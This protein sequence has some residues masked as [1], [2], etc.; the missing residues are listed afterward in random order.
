MVRPG[1]VIPG[2]ETIIA[3]KMSYSH[4]FSFDLNDLI[5][6]MKNIVLAGLKQACRIIIDCV[7]E[8]FYKQPNRAAL[9]VDMSYITMDQERWQ[10][11]LVD[12]WFRRSS[13]LNSDDPLQ[14]LITRLATEI[15]LQFRTYWAALNPII[16]IPVVSVDQVQVATKGVEMEVGGDLVAEMFSSPTSG[17]DVT[18]VTTGG[19]LI[20]VA[21]DSYGIFLLRQ[22]LGIPG[23]I[24]TTPTDR[25]NLEITDAGSIGPYQQHAVQ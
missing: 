1:L 13:A 6:R 3:N 18:I 25:L 23:G 14:I 21:G 9:L 20:E 15:P 7:A 5:R 24:A 8:I 2:Y 19:G 16:K 12:Q 11:T 10:I 17:E 4:A 22:W